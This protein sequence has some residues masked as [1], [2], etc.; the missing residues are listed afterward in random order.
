MVYSEII[1]SG[2]VLYS[3][4]TQARKPIRGDLHV[5]A[6]VYLITRGKTIEGLSARMG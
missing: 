2:N 4:P 6:A 3:Q 5:A 1:S